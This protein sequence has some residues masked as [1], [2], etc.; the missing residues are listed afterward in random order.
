METR[1]RTELANLAKRVL[2][3][4]LDLHGRARRIVLA[5]FLSPGSGRTLDAGCGNGSLSVLAAKRGHEVIAISNDEAALR[6][7]RSFFKKGRANNVTFELG[8]LYELGTW[9][10]ASFDQVVCSE[11][12]EH[13]SDDK[14]VVRHFFRVLRPG[15]QLILCV[16]NRLHPEHNLGRTNEPENGQH[17]RDGYTATELA[18]LVCSAGFEVRHSG[19]IGGDS[20]T[21]ADR[22]VRTIRHY[23]GEALAIPAFAV[24]LLGLALDDPMPEVP[25]SVY[26]VAAKPLS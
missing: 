1:L 16:P 21:R 14:I 22:I 9:Q 26:L 6:R 24:G 2:F 23:V 3:P 11:V 12:I 15:G 19:G 5:Q 17:V 8:N 25:Y 13:L 10:E 20:V 4:G 18:A 7:A